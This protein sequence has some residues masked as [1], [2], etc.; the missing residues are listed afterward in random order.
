[1][2]AIGSALPLSGSRSRVPGPFKYPNLRESNMT[3]NQQWDEWADDIANDTGEAV[4]LKATNVEDYR[5]LLKKVIKIL[6][7]NL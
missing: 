7:E 6:K 3:S 1:M 2:L 4:A 5:K